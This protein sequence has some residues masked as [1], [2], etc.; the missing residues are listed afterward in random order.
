MLTYRTM[1]Q[2]Y[3]HPSLA[4]WSSRA[5]YLTLLLLAHLAR[6]QEGSQGNTTIFGGAQATFF[7]NHNFL[8]GGG[9]TQP[10]VIGTVRSAPFGVLNFAST[11][12]GHI[13]ANDANHVD[14]Y[15]RKLGTG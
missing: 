11:A 4:A 7:G 5:V 6:A 14:G 15:V 8:T 9:S 1:R 10:G 3:I 12:T 2:L 13:G